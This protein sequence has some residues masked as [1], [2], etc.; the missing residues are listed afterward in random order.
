MDNLEKGNPKAKTFQSC[1]MSQ[2]TRGEFR[3][4]HSERST[5]KHNGSA[6]HILIALLLRQCQFCG[7]TCR[8]R[9][10]PVK[11]PRTGC[12]SSAKGPKAPVYYRRHPKDRCFKLMGVIENNSTLDSNV[13]V[14]LDP[15]E[16]KTP[17]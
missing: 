12:L 17:G 1:R 5:L 4:R 11:G 9:Q 8:L 13:S 16:E 15:G 3:S 2:R 14:I 6:L 7:N 10:N